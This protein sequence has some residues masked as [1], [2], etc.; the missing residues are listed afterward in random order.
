MRR[1]LGAVFGV[2][3]FLRLAVVLYA[4]ARFPPAADGTFYDVFAHRLAEGA[5]YTWQW[6]D[7]VV[8]HAAHYPVGY[9]LLLSFGY[10]LWASP[11]SAMLVN[12]LFGA[13][14]AVAGADLLRAAGAAPRRVF[15]GGLALASHPALLFYVPALM[16]EGVTV[17]IV[18]AAAALAARARD[19]RRGSFV[20]MGLLLGVATLVRP[21]SLATAPFFG[22]L[23]G[24]PG[25]RRRVFVRGALGLAIA[26]LVCA[27]WTLRNCERMHRCALVSV[28]GGWNLLIG[29]ETANGAWEEVKVPEACR[30]V[31]DEA[32]KDA[33]FEREARRAIVSRP[34]AWIARMPKKL[35]ATFDYFGAAPW[36]L[37]ASNAAAVSERGKVAL[38]V[39][40]T[41]FARIA[42]LVAATRFA[43]ATRRRSGA[44]AKAVT[45][46]AVTAALF[47]VLRTA[48][49]AYVLLG[50]VAGGHAWAFTRAKATTNSLY[51]TAAVQIGLTAA[52]HAAFFG[53]GRYGLAVAPFVVLLAFVPHGTIPECDP[54][55]P[56]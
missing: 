22:A 41:V 50:A 9:P 7:G 17:G 27:P 44:V 52:F 36:Y 42:L 20:G 4:H 19:G 18:L 10:R 45:A 12:A 6:P 16:T 49:P 25:S 46:A 32:E 55:A 51:I 53:G 56:A 30:T 40:E 13:V 5:G 38:A 24:A 26:L 8:T 48:W 14:G 15:L 11:T 31:W 21:Q 3:L 43:L 37:H 35:G 1:A 54:A 23:A 47:A 29:A 34:T 2:A 28:N 33:C 39:V